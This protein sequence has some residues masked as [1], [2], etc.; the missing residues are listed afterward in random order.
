VLADVLIV[1]LGV[2]S[3]VLVGFASRRVLDTPVGWPRSIVVGLLVFVCGL[4]FGRWVTEQTGIVSGDRADLE[5]SAL[6][7]WIV[8]L[9]SIAWVFA[10]GVALLVAL[11]LVWP[12][13]SL[14]NP[15]DTVRAALRQ[16][17][18]TRRYAQI[19]AIASRRGVG[20]VFHGHARSGTG[21]STPAE[22]AAAIVDTINE[23]GVTF[24]KLGQVLSTRRDLIPE[25][26]L[27]ALGSL[28]SAATTLPWSVVGPEIE[29]ELG[30]PIAEVFSSVSETPL[31][32][33]SVAQV[34]TA[35]L[36]DGTA[37]VVKVQRP[38][39]RAQVEADVD[40][41]VRLAQRAEKHS[42]QA[43][44]LRAESVARGFTTTLLAELDYRVEY[45]NT[46]MLRSTLRMIGEH[47]HADDVRISVPRVYPAASSQR[48]LTMDL[49]DGTPL[50]AAD[51]RLASMSD[52]SRD[53]LAA[54]LMN[55]VLEQ[56]LVH[57]VFHADLH[58]GNVILK[59]DGSL[60]LIDF[61]AVG[62]IER[63]QRHN[64]SALLLAA[65]CEDD[66]AAT[67]ALMLIVDVPDDTDVDAFRH[68]IGVVLTTVQHRAGGE[69]SIFS[70][71]LDVIRQHH[72]A[73]P[74]TLS[75]AFRSFATL[76]GC[77][78]VLVPDFDLA[79]RALARMPALTRRAL[80]AKRIAASAQ[81]QAA[82]LSAYARKLP[83][84]LETLASQLERGTLNVRV[85]SFAAADDQWFVGALVS[86]I[87][88]VLVS[89]T[90]VVLAI[91]LVVSDSG[92]L[93][94]PQLGLFDLLGAFVGFLGFLG[95]LRTVRRIFI[96]RPRAR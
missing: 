55:A 78:K 33:A 72:L 16:R 21:H 79:E 54:G 66:I 56:I 20:W 73:L 64:L 10:I 49:V 27:S 28:Q 41:I 7:A 58:P 32:A 14:R 85:R 83:R 62:I 94:A 26:Y 81:A 52:E 45:S 53:R 31:A 25:P 95:I 70:L 80:S 51:A 84:R 65:A 19:L 77:L 88:G 4:P 37:V 42:L 91:V 17:K 46:E 63:S 96:R 60:G 12:T 61:G 1:V 8:V 38:T 67:D 22:R 92:P 71:M 34:H 57:G 3:A 82:V 89:I 13:A 68:D 29:A 75:S 74:A 30:R 18:R 5:S 69:G 36:L 6:V 48:M 23:S 43:R 90:A 93:L 50:S 87:L 76:E 35:R 40:I 59:D 86:E 2:L 44:E 24:V 15:I 9:L 39:A 11:E 47:A